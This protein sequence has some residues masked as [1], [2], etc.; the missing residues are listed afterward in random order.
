MILHNMHMHSLISKCASQ[1]MTM[2]RIITEAEKAGIQTIGISDHIDSPDSDRQ[3]QLLDNFEI[4]EQLHPSIDVR[5][6]CET[7]Q[8]N[9]GTI[10][11]DKETAQQLDFVL[12]ASNHYHLSRVENPDDKSPSG[13]AAHYLR[14]VEGAID[15]GYTTTIAHPFLLAKVRDIEHSQVLASYD[16]NEL[17]R[18]LQKAVEKNVSFELS[19]RHLRHAMDFFKE[20]VDFGR[21]VGLKFVP[22]TDAHKPHDI[23]YNAED[24]ETLNSLG[25]R[26]QDFIAA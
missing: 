7:S 15:W 20:L 19:P 5:I 25:V 16:R 9:P 23:A 17:H 6:G 10:A 22:G 13:Y 26:E 11:V 24:I 12:V 1:E 14:M 18:V 21:R 8:L 4:L 2:E 3:N